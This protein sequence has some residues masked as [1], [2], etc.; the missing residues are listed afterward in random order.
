MKIA[1]AHPGVGPFVQQTARAL[2]EAG[3]LASYWTTFADQPEAR[4]RRA[5]VQLASAVGLDMERELQR[6]AVTE[7]P[8]TFLR[9]APFWEI[10]RSLLAK[11]KA[12]PRLVDSIW[13]HETL[14][15]DRKVAANGLRNVGGIYGY[16]FCS[17]ASFMEAERRGLARVYEVPAPEHDFV[18]GL[19]Q[20]EIKQ[21]PELGDDKRA[22]FLARQPRR[23]ERRRREWALADVVIANSNFTRDSYASAGL[24][25]SKVRVIPLGAP[26]VCERGTKGGSEGQEPFRVLWAGTFSIRKGAHHLLNAWRSIAAKRNATLAIYG[27]IELPRT[28]MSSLPSSIELSSTVSRAALF[29][30]YRASDM[31]VFPTL[32]D[33]FGMVVTEAFAHGLPVITTPRAGAADLVRHGENGLI[34]PAGDS[35]ALAEALEWCI[36]HRIELKAMRRSA[37]ETAARWQWSDYRL[38]LARNVEEGLREAGYGA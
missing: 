2:L 21:I 27:A 30:H 11:M 37:I 12:D 10:V 1:L 15:F 18:E 14:K 4:W 20:Q 33:G 5:L 28:L 25:V 17:L 35:H 23:T 24:N 8:T 26:P 34:V 32:C 19:I 38:A 31:L 9:L 3:L 29:E 13:E 7:V 6:R 16:E 22:Y 36:T